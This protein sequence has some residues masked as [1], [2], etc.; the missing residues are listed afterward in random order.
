MIG[1]ELIKV[2]ADAVTSGLLTG[3]KSTPAYPVSLLFIAPLT[4]VTISIFAPNCPEWFQ[5]TF[6]VAAVLG[7]LSY[8]GATIWAFVK[9]PDRL[10]SEQYRLELRKMERRLGVRDEPAARPL[11]RDLPGDG[12][13]LARLLPQDPHETQ[14]DVDRS[15]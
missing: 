7:L 1:A 4:A 3:R 8:G 10:E 2:A 13:P 9:Q 15:S 6:A 11:T 5:I 14:S 12:S